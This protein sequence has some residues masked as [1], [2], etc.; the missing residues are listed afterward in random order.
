MIAWITGAGSGIGRAIALRLSAAGFTVAASGRGREALDALCRESRGGTILPVACDVSS[1]DAVRDAHEHIRTEAGPVDVL[2]NNA[3][4]TVFL[5]FL[6]TTVER[7]D[8]LTATNLRGTFLCAQAVLP[9]MLERRAGTIVMI[10]SMASREVF[11]DSSAYAATKAGLKAMTDCLRLEH[12]RD[13][14][15]VIGVYPGATD[16]AIWPERAREKY[17]AAMMPPDDVAEAVAMA[18][19]LPQRSMVEDLYIQP[20]GGP[21]G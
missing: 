6:K 19:L 16:T 18:V 8:E 3:G 15:R 1:P 7:F 10:N 13:G 5:P 4:T 21:L 20:I 9:S 11:R 2:V 14:I 12:R 17:R